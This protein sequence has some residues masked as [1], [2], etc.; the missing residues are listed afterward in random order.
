VP[1]AW[2]TADELED[3]A[4]E[5]ERRLEALDPPYDPARG[6]G[7]Y[8]DRGEL[9]V[10]ESAA[11]IRV[12]EPFL[13][14]PLAERIRE[15]GSL[16]RCRDAYS[17]SEP[18]Y[19][20]L[21][22]YFLQ[23]RAFYDPEFW[24]ESAITIQV[25]RAD[26][27]EGDADSRNEDWSA[28][29]ADPEETPSIFQPFVLRKPQRDFLASLLDDFFAGEPVRWNLVKARQWGGSTLVQ[30]LMMWVQ[31]IR[32]LG[33]NISIVADVKGQALHIRGM[34]DTA[35]RFYPDA[36][37]D[38]TFT[39]YQG[40]SNVKRVPER[41]AILGVASTK[42]P[43][44]VRSYTY[45]MLH[46]SEVGLWKSTPAHNAEDLAQALEGGL[47]GGSE[48]MC[49]RES[50]AKGVGNYFHR[51][52]EAAEKG[53]SAYDNFFVGWQEIDE[54]TKDVPDS[55]FGAFVRSWSSYERWLWDQGATVEGIK[56][57]RWKK[58]TLP[59]RSADWRMKAEYPTTAEEAFQSTGR[60]VFR[61][62]YVQ[63][64]RATTRTPKQ[65]GRMHALGPTGDRALEDLEF[66]P[67]DH[68]DIKVWREPGDDFGGLLDLVD[69]RVRNRYCAFMDVGARYE[70]GDW[71]V[72]T[73]LDRAPMLPILDSPPEVAAVYR[74]HMDQDLAA[75][76]AVQ[77]CAW[78][79][80]ALLAIE[81]NSLRRRAD[82][83]VEPDAN[84]HM[85]VLDEIREVYE[86]WL[87]YTTDPEA[88]E[89]EPHRKF[90]FHT[91]TQTKPMII[92]ALNAAI[93]DG[94]YVERATGACDE[95][96][97]YEIKDDGRMG[98]KEGKHDD[99]V[100]SRAGA[101]WLALRHMRPP[102]LIE[103]AK[104][105]SRGRK[106]GMAVFT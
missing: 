82:D 21:V 45:H 91:N 84:H 78:Y 106:A 9:R 50:T 40:M 49:I 25:K 76:Y 13:D 3:L 4:R 6:I 39:A 100:I 105:S 52:F 15:A 51:E 67:E 42:N 87:F 26:D 29:A 92:D 14:T 31:Q 53:G 7:C 75:W 46:L 1:D 94:T 70:G 56:W 83:G 8:G 33:W 68:G 79:E 93:R 23:Q 37:G 90:G 96:D 10:S 18:E 86:R 11:P 66:V 88:A 28:A 16:E 95:M 57:Y 20:Q 71:H 44:A 12:P 81:K 89:D 102:K 58:S 38:I 24:F 43:D 55:E 60:R 104:G 61:P 80:N 85:T 62:S 65:K 73:I 99:R 41:E 17:L 59:D 97:Y 72:V 63:N 27:E 34:Y 5:N 103:R 48:T 98:A 54:Y 35:R 74:G 22:R 30:L 69:H 32:R 19:R 77:L 101:V 47:V 2:T 64:A 36:F